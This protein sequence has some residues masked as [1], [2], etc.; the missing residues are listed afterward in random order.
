MLSHIRGSQK[1]TP[2]G[3]ISRKRSFP[4]VVSPSMGSRRD[5]AWLQPFWSYRWIDF[6][7]APVA[8]SVF[9]SGGQSEVQAVIQQF[10]DNHQLRNHFYCSR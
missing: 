5:A 3:A 10:P 8:D 7:C 2:K 1:I 6:T 9:A 4:M